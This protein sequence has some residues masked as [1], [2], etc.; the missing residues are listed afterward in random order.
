[1]IRSNEKAL[2]KSGVSTVLDQ[3]SKQGIGVL[4]PAKYD[5][6]I[7]Q[8]NVNFPDK[9]KAFTD[10]LFDGTG[11]SNVMRRLSKSCESAAFPGRSVS[12]QPNRVAGPVR[13]MPYESLYSG[14]LDL[15]FRVGQDMFERTFFEYWMDRI[16][17][18]STNTMGYYDDYT[19]DIYITQ[20]NPN[21]EIVY[22]IR[23][24]ECYPKAINAIDLGFDKTDEYTRQSVSIAFR[25]YITLDTRGIVS[26]TPVRSQFQY[27]SETDKQ[28]TEQRAR[29]K[30][31]LVGRLLNDADRRASTPIN[32]SFSL[33]PTEIQ[34]TP[35]FDFNSDLSL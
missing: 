22:K 14:D 2:T 26:P 31:E 13:E 24:T 33:N 16:V 35:I 25:E 3:F 30:Q 7:S 9:S 4:S 10:E 19:R 11:N 28:Y 6:I 18:H 34:N 27:G 12:T 21:D 15:T 20:L 17:N 5:I 29:E 8:P 1:M 23:L 32:T